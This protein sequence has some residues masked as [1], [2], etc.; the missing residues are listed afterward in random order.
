[1]KKLKTAWQNFA[2][3]FAN[4]LG[5]AIAQLLWL[6]KIHYQQG[7]EGVRRAKGGT[8]FILNHTWW[9][10]AAILC[11]L[12]LRRR[13][14]A[15]VAMDV[16][17]KGH[18]IGGLHSLR[19]IC[20]DRRKPDLSFLHEALGILRAGGCVAIFPEGQL[21]PTGTLLPFKQGAAMLA[22]QAGVPVVPVY[23]AGN[24]Q[25]FQRLQLMFGRP[26][27]LTQRPSAAGVQ[28]ATQVLQDAMQ[29]LR[30]ELEQRMKPKYLARSRRFREKFAAKLQKRQKGKEV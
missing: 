2:A 20:V 22:L 4:V 12:C 11:I 30:Q 23:S 24:Y 27:T 15:V 14:H 8:V 6:P 16:A 18:A 28:E 10:D 13:I 5:G 1:M 29:N 19:C 25:P 17:E 9:F 3:D 26:I 21:N 7:A